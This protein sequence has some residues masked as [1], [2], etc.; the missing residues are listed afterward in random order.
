[1]SREVIQ[2]QF[3]KLHPH[4]IAPRQGTAEAA[5][6][7]LVAVSTES[8]LSHDMVV[9]NT[10]LAVA[11]A[12]GHVLKIY[13]RSGLAFKYGI[14]LING[15]GIIDSDYRGEIKLGMVSDRLNQDGLLSHL[16]PGTRV[17]QAILEKL[18]ETVWSE[19]NEL[20]LTMRGEGGFGSTGST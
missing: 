2:I 10:G 19:V 11:F 6:F 13:P 7:D 8:F 20:P 17:A 14:H 3:K 16:Q 15:V 12:P 1:M 9:V 4:A 18:P 5:G